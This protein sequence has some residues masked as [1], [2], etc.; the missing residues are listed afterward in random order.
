LD[1]TD[2]PLNISA[3]ERDTGLSKDTLRIWERRY[4]FPKPARDQHGERVYPAGQVE[5]LRLIKRLMDRGHR[6]G[7]IIGQS[8]ESLR[9]LGSNSAKDSSPS[10][11]LDIFLKLIRSH[12]LQELRSLLSQTMARQG[13][14]SF[15]LETVAPLNVAVGEAWMDGRIAVYEE[16]LYSELVQNLLR[17]AISAIQPHGGTPRVLLTSLPQEQHGIGLL[18]A[19]AMLVVEGASCI[20]L[21]TQ[22]P[23]AD[24][25]TAARAH[26]ADIVALSFS[27]SYPE[28]KAAEGLK[29]LRLA[30]PRAT[31]LWAGGAG[32]TRL[33][34]PIEGVQSIPSFERMVDL[35]KQWRAPSA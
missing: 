13:L 15:I 6:P 2:D 29:Q 21:G 8:V 27:S 24:I 11:D 1:N 12:Q 31:Q 3:V 28:I 17:N 33:R 20:P 32:T 35:V 16:H 7:K 19:E 10:K 9:A 26:H 18:M 34:K 4:E 22:T 14:Q 5:K 25:V 23:L 30:L